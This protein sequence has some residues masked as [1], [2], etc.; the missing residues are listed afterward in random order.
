MISE[1]RTIEKDLL[2]TT[3]AKTPL[4]LVRL[5]ADYQA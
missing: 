3:L 1:M 5:Q 4:N 2:L